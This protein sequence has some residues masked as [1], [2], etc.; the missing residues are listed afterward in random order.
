MSAWRGLFLLSLAACDC[1]TEASPPISPVPERDATPREEASI[2]WVG[3]SLMSHRDRSDPSSATLPELVGQ[4]AEARGQGHTAFEHLNDGASFADNWNDETRRRELESRG[5]TYDVLVLTPQLTLENTFR[6]NAPAHWGRRFVCLALEKN[7]DVDTFLYETWHHLQASDPKADYGPP[8]SWNWRI[9]LDADRAR[10]L[11]LADQ[12]AQGSAPNDDGEEPP[13]TPPRPLKIIPVGR[14]FGM[15]YDQLHPRTLEIELL[16]QNPHRRWPEEWPISGFSAWLT[17]PEDILAEIPLVYPD[18]ELD[19][20]HPSR[21]GI[22]VAA[23]VHYATIY[24]SSPVGL[25]A[26]QGVAPDVTAEL[27]R[28]AWEAVLVEPRSGVKE[29]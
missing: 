23:L 25:P 26:L 19:D 3:H 9:R 7:P 14:A 29:E 27:Q 6:Y 24:R 17:S 12:I 21:I 1:G 5:E 10:W 18:L 8:Q 13:C 16:L 15:V 28:I 11:Q 2:Y 4:F 22:Y 20:I